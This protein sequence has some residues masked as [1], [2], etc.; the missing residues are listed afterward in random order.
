MDFDL[1]LPSINLRVIRGI[2]VI[3]AKT[4]TSGALVPE[5]VHHIILD[6]LAVPWGKNNVFGF[7]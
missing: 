4:G 1:V 7:F 6:V 3:F 2:L 5:G